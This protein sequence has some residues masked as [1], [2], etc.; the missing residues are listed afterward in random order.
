VGGDLGCAPASNYVAEFAI[1]TI[2]AELEVPTGPVQSQFGYHVILV[3]ERTETALEDVR[4]EIVAGL[5]E[6]QRTTLLSDW[7]LAVIG[8]A[9][10]TVEEEYGTWELEPFPTVVPPA[11]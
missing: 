4:G 9:D 5:R 11:L 2:E 7:M 3:R 6:Q 1:A 10:V 8:G